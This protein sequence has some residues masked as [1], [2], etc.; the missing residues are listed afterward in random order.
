M[1]GSLNHDVKSFHTMSELCNEFGVTPR[2]LRFYEQRA[3]LMPLRQ[4]GRRLFSAADRDR[5][6]LV[7]RTKRWGFTLTEIAN[8]LEVWEKGDRTPAALWSEVPKLRERL[9][10]LKQQSHA[11]NSAIRDLEHS[12]DMLV[13]P[14]VCALEDQRD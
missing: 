5:L 4:S 14:V 2:T 12:C 10:L 6:Q 1:Q 13:E 11:L 3:L 8:L 7:L 9:R